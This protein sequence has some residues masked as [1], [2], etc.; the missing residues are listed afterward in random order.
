MFLHHSL[1]M[2]LK[3]L[4]LYHGATVWKSLPNLLKESQYVNDFKTSYM[5]H[6][7]SYVLFSSF[8]WSE[9]RTKGEMPRS[10]DIE[11]LLYFIFYMIS[12]AIIGLIVFITSL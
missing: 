8:W 4:F 1:D 12:I 2:K 5:K 9:E 11:F 3:Q 7:F 10:Y 6:Y